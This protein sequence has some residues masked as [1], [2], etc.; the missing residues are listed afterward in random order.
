MIIEPFK[1]EH[2]ENLLIQPAQA[3]MRP[4]MSNP[5]YG[6]TLAMGPAYSALEGGLVLGCAGVIPLWDNRA[7][8]WALM[9]ADL[10]RHFVRIH[11]A[12]LRFLDGCPIRRIE[13]HCDADFC[14]AK[15]WL[16]LLG[17]QYEGFMRAFTPD[18]RDAL[19]YARVR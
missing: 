8:A 16:E 2:I 12:A 19:R 11:R 3:F 1:P 17:F 9:G 5:D 7:E 13:A 6:R 14:D 10:K 4:L 15:T 18:G